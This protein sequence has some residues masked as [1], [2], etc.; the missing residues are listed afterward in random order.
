MHRNVHDPKNKHGRLDRENGQ[1]L[2]VSSLTVNISGDRQTDVI[3]HFG[4]G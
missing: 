1:N 2:D 3:K 4:L